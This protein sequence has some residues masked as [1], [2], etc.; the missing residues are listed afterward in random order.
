MHPWLAVWIWSEAISR[1]VRDSILGVSNNGVAVQ[2]FEAARRPIRLGDYFQT[3]IVTHPLPSNL[4]DR[5][6]DLY[7]TERESE[8]PI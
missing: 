1:I 7:W 3:E 2:P 5:L 4:L 6:A 8:L